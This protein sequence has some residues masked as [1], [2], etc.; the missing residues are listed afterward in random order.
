MAQTQAAPKNGW[1]NGRKRDPGTRPVRLLTAAAAQLNL[2]DRKEARRIR[3]LRQGWQTEAWNYRNSIGELRY[4]INFLANAMAR[5]KIYPAMYPLGAE[6]DSPVPL[7]DAVGVPPEVI[8]ACTQA[9]LDLGNGRLAM[10][11]LLH[12]LST[13]LSVTGECFLVG[14]TNPQTGQDTWEIRSVDEIIVFDDHYK[15]REVPVDP[16]GILG[17]VDLDPELTVVSRVWIPSPQFRILADSAVKAIMDDCESLLIMRRMI[18]ATGRSRLAGRGLLLIPD[19]VSIKVDG[20]DND[21]PE[22]DPFMAQLAEMMTTPISD[23]GVASAVVPGVIRGPGDAL[24]KVRHI[25]FAGQFDALASKTR[26]EIVGIIATGL[27]LPK[28]VITGM[29]DLNHWSAW[30]VDDNTFRHH[31]EPHVIV[32]CDSLTAA[33]LRPYL[34]NEGIDPFWVQRIVFWYD[35]TELVTHPDQTSDA[36]QLHDRLVISNAALLRVSGFSET[37]APDPT[38]FE[39][40]MLSKMRTWPVNA[41]LALMHELDPTLTFPAIGGPGI[42]P[43]ISS[44]GVDVPQIAPPIGAAPTGPVAPAPTVNPTPPAAPDSTVAPGPPS[45]TAAGKSREAERAKRLSRKLVAIDQDLRARL[46]VA[47]NAAVVRQLEKTGGRIRSKVAK[48]ETLRTKIAHR[49][50]EVVVA[51]L[52]KEVM[53]A[54]GFSTEELA[55]SDFGAL[56]ELFFNLTDSARGQALNIASQLAGI[57]MDSR[58][59]IAASQALSQGAQI[60]WPL[61]HEALSKIAAD[62]L[63]TPDP[64]VLPGLAELNPD[65]VV[66]TGVIRAA[67]GVVGGAKPGDMG[68]NPAGD[69]TIPLG[70]P[71]GQIA[72]GTT[73]GNLLT[74][75]GVGSEGY[76]WVHGPSL[77][78]FSPHEDLDGVTFTSFDDPALQNADGWP[79]NA[80]FMP[81]DHAGCLCDF[82]PLWVPNG[83]R[84]DDP[85]AANPDDAPMGLSDIAAMD[86]GGMPTPAQTAPPVPEFNAQAALSQTPSE[87]GGQLLQSYSSGIKSS[88]NLGGGVQAEQG[89]VRLT[90][91]NDKTKAIIKDGANQA[92]AD[93][94]VLSAKVQDALGLHTANTTY[95][96]GDSTSVLMRYSKGKVAYKADFINET[97]SKRMALSD[98]VTSQTDRHG[99]N[100]MIDADG[101][102]TGIDNGASFGLNYKGVSSHIEGLYAPL[103][104]TTAH[105]FSDYATR[106]IAARHSALNGAR[107]F[108]STAFTDADLAKAK[109]ALQ[110]LKPEFD[111]AGRSQWHDGMMQQL[112]ALQAAPIKGTINLL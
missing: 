82:M 84:A 75:N 20:E 111:A 66:P 4:A 107:S 48:D 32:G 23:E 36:L 96:P 8:A 90:T 13:N 55:G 50:N 97:D 53:T 77:R 28:E 24:D 42:I 47:A 112:G 101:R 103:D 7:D 87:W 38:E 76:E 95:S 80:F 100:S 73:L 93:A 5:M 19:E 52:G 92:Q 86:N 9:I 45:V 58:P 61:F 22:S 12:S 71:I 35:P 109:T 15:L 17:W 34:E 14:Q 2:N 54:V 57:P 65:T 85:S 102:I 40:R 39:I 70:K 91:F 41:V 43:G 37:D 99:A 68:I 51:T 46:Q 11:N 88:K 21:D 59:I 74:D 81:G 89:M 94:E 72:T 30:A 64:N 105:Y 33:Y 1:F 63:Y 110:A 62:K 10:R 26:D 67:L 104:D 69:P 3:V 56:R 106:D 49:K 60:A 98:I 108:S 31:I 27:D 25:D 78:P 16:Q 6:S 83:G 29:T 79:Y 18:R 44:E